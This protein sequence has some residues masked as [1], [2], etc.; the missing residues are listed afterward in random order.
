MSEEE[1]KNRAAELHYKAAKEC[2]KLARYAEL[3]AKLLKDAHVHTIAEDY[4][5]AM[6]LAL[7]AANICSTVAERAK[8]VTA[9]LHEARTL[10]NELGAAEKKEEKKPQ[11]WGI[12][13]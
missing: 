12:E 7:T 8:A 10:K 13:I 3:A 2:E 11:G 5:A 6:Q 1:G 9:W 4:Y